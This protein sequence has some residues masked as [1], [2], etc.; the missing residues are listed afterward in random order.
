M[1]TYIYIYIYSLYIYIYISRNEVVTTQSVHFTKE[2]PQKHGFEIEWI[3]LAH[4]TNKNI[5][6]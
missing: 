1:Y 2:L 5:V 6:V 4:S 3:W